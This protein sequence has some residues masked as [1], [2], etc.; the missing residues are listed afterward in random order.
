M[1][2]YRKAQMNTV[3]PN[4]QTQAMQSLFDLTEAMNEYAQNRQRAEDNIRNLTEQTIRYFNNA[5]M[6]TDF[7]TN[8]ME[9]IETGTAN[10]LENVSVQMTSQQSI[11]PMNV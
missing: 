6:P 11:G 1:K 9:V 5:G 4:A 2:I 10:D 3:D 7:L 8:L